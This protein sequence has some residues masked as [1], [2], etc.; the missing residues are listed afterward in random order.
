MRRNLPAQDGQQPSGHGLEIPAQ[1]T[2]ARDENVFESRAD[3]GRADGQEGGRVVVDAMQAHHHGLPRGGR[4]V[5]VPAREPTQGIGEEDQQQTAQAGAHAR[6]QA[7]PGP[8]GAGGGEKRMGFVGQLVIKKGV[9]QG[10]DK[11]GN[12][13]DEGN[14]GVEDGHG[15]SPGKGC[16]NFY[17]SILAK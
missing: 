17:I 9:T 2:V 15:P 3:Q 14:Q 5:Q 11:T 13:H 12:Q 7:C 16:R 10:G 6:K 4:G 8:P 1:G